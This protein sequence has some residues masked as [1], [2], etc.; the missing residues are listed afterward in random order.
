MRR[1][2]QTVG[3][4][5]RRGELAQK[6]L[7]NGG[8]A[9]ATGRCARNRAISSNGTERSR[10][11]AKATWKTR[12]G[13]TAA[14]INATINAAINAATKGTIAGR[15]QRPPLGDTAPR[16]QLSAT[17]QAHA[18]RARHVQRFV[19]LSG[20]RSLDKGVI[21]ATIASGGGAVRT[22]MPILNGPVIAER[23]AACGARPADSPVVSER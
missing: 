7:S 8:T 2:T 10:K 18:V 23:K 13:A 15:R 5:S 11:M 12:R 20:R 19:A 9:E 3:E 17:T 21:C 22:G 1:G 4:K 14:T 16:A 6:K